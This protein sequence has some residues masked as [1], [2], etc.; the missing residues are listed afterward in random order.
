VTEFAV[1]RT[2]LYVVNS[3]SFF[4]SHRLAIA[5]AAR[6]AGYDVQVATMNGDGIEQIISHGFVHHTLPM[7]RSGINPLTELRTLLAIW[8]LLRRVRPDIVHLVT[9]KPVIYGGL[10]AR[11]TRVPAVVAA[12][13][14]LG[15][16]FIARGLRARIVRW[17]AVWSYRAALRNSRLCAVFQNR[18]DLDAFVRLGIVRTAQSTIVRGSGVDLA[19]FAPLPESA[20][21]PVV[22]MASRLLVDKGVREFVEAARLLRA[23]GA[24]VRFQLAGDVDPGNSASI[25]AAELDVWRG[26]GIVE[27]LG[28]RC[29]IAQVFAAASVVV[30]PSYREGLPKVLIEAAACGRAVVTTDVPGCRDAIEPGHTGLLVP[31]RDAGALADAIERLVADRE[32]RASLGRMGRALAEREFDVRGV[33]A[34]HLAIYQNCGKARDQ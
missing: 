29:D 11:A 8:I 9:I 24:A 7:T 31:P 32:L 14:G 5:N 27:L 23:R 28:Q 25:D 21:P 20:T 13:S 10:A 12:I 22:V 18:N 19:E 2:L 6:T 30:L 33:I 1:R 34:A 17:V 15:F 4:L 26:Q 16:V 3:P